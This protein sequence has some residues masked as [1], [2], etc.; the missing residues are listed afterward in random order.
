[1]LLRPPARPPTGTPTASRS[2]PSTRA[3]ACRTRRC[4][5]RDGYST[6]GHA[7]AWPGRDRAAG[8]SVRHLHPTRRHGH[9]RADLARSVRPPNAG[10]PRYDIGAV[11]VSKTGEDV[12]GDDWGWRMRDG[13]LAHLRRRRARARPA[14]ARS[15]AAATRVFAAGHEQ[16]PARLD[17]GRSRRAAA[18]PRRR[19]RDAGGRP[20]AAAAHIAGLGNISGV[21]AAAGRGPAQHGVPQRNGRPHRRADPGVQLPGPAGAI[22]VMFS[23]GL[24]THWDLSAYPG[25][26]QRSPASSP[27][28]CIAI[29]AGG[30]TT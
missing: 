18:D 7:R 24:S 8:R 2:S 16:P 27:V 19:G 4:S 21:D 5:R 20:R 26:R 25:L 29:S 23:D 6:A 30:A 9:R 28:S 17:R 11:H 10:R 13:R 12:C 1:M 3:R 22:I 15:R 14:G